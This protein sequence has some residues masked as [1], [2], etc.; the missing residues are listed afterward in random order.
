MPLVYL[1]DIRLNATLHGP[2]DAPALVFVHALGTD[3]TLWDGT[4]AALGSRYRTL[5]YDQRG[6]GASD[7]PKPPYTMGAMIRD[8]ESLIDHFALRDAVIVG[9]SLGGLVAQGLAVK[10]LDL[11]RGLVLSNTAARIGTPELWNARITEVRQTGLATSKCANSRSCGHADRTAHRANG[12][13]SHCAAAR[14]H[15]RCQ[16]V[17]A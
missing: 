15:A 17:V 9:V 5:S 16:V 2:E 10:R 6:H 13:S 3:L 14:T 1:P 7:V 4:I 8:A 11:V 12:C